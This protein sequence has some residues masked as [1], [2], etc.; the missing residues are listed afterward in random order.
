MKKIILLF[1]TLS[2]GLAFSQTSKTPSEKTKNKIPSNPYHQVQPSD[3][4]SVKKENSKISFYKNVDS[5]K[6][7]KYR[8]L[9]KKPSE[10]FLELPQ[11]KEINQKEKNK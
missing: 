7:S 9:S 8:M 2:F 11:N 10:Q 4:A 6:A 1:A 3:T 5:A